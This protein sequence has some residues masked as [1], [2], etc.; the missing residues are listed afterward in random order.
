MADLCPRLRRI[1][2]RLFLIDSRQILFLTM[3]F[4]VENKNTTTRTKL[5]LLK[6]TTSNIACDVPCHTEN[7]NAT[8]SLPSVII[9]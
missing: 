7:W 9:L 6:E 2:Y 1:V 4:N 5:Y 8:C 3:S